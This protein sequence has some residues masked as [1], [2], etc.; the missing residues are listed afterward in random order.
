M[1]PEIGKKKIIHLKDDVKRDEQNQ[2]AI[3]FGKPLFQNLRGSK[4]L[5]VQSIC[6]QI[7]V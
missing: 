4:H 6:I 3:Y 1:K 7:I 5:I 2:N